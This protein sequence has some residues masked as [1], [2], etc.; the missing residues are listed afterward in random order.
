MDNDIPTLPGYV[1]IKEAAKTLGISERRVYLYVETKRLAAVRAADVL[2]I[3]L[4]EVQNFRRKFAGRPRKN[5]PPWRISSADNA[6]FMTSINVQV[7]TGREKKLMRRLEELKRS[8]ANT[9]PGTIARYVAGRETH[10][11]RIEIALIWRSTVMPDEAE[12]EQAL[13][14]FR[15]AL[16]D[17][18]DWDTA[19]YDYGK[20][21]MHT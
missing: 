2:L 16:A 9:F 18:P 6:Q 14:E 7:R 13:G 20:V 12:R 8:G 17:V 15:Q 19:H 4:Q 21:Y 10:P 3:P 1:S 5:T 11:E